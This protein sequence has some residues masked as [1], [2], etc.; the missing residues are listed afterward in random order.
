MELV[1]ISPYLHFMRKLFVLL[2]LLIFVGGHSLS[3][4]AAHMQVESG[5]GTASLTATAVMP[6]DLA[7]KDNG[8]K[9]RPAASTDSL[10]C[11]SYCGLMV[12]AWI[13]IYPDIKPDVFM[14]HFPVTSTITINEHFRPPI[15]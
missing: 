6:S 9:D 10:H 7:L 11:V 2:L 13:G 15:G 5:K 4:A 1:M 3:D 8:S 12:A 14:G